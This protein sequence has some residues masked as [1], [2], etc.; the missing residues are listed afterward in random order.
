[1]ERRYTCRAWHETFGGDRLEEVEVLAEIRKDDPRRRGFRVRRVSTGEEFNALSHSIHFDRLKGVE[2]L[3][4]RLEA[5]IR[6]LERKIKE[7]EEVVRQYQ[8]KIEILKN[9]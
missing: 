3:V 2:K 6:I 1:M 7:C 4:P 9:G 8:E 5:G